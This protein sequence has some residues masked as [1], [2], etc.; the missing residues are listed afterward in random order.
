MVSSPLPAEQTWSVGFVLA[1]AVLLSFNADEIA[2]KISHLPSLA[3]PTLVV[4]TVMVAA[5]A[6]PTKPRAATPARAI[7][8]P[9]LMVEIFF[10]SFIPSPSS[11]WFT[12]TFAESPVF[13]ASGILDELP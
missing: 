12:V 8:P 6:A 10:I 9:R 1:A 3:T 11:L 5:L 4:L 7:N 2:S 13:D